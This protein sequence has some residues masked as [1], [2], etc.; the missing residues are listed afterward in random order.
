MRLDLRL[1]S[2][3]ATTITVGHD[4]VDCDGFR[5]RPVVKNGV[6]QEG[7]WA[8][9]WDG[10]RTEHKFAAGHPPYIVEAFTVSDRGVYWPRLLGVHQDLH[11]WGEPQRTQGIEIAVSL[12]AKVS[13]STLRWDYAQPTKFIFNWAPVDGFVDQLLER[14]IEPLLYPTAF[15]SW[16]PG[17][18]GESVL[19]ASAADWNATS[20]AYVA[21]CAAAADRYRGRVRHWEIWNEPN[22]RWFWSYGSNDAPARVVAR[23]RYCGMYLAARAAILT[24]APD[25]RVA[26]GGLTGLGASGDPPGSGNQWLTDLIAMPQI[27]PDNLSHLAIHPYVSN[28]QGPDDE[29]PWQ[30]HFSDIALIRGT[31]DAHGYQDTELWATEFGWKSTAPL[32]ETIQAQYVARALERLRDDFPYVTLATYFLDADQQT[33]KHGLYRDDRVTEKPA[34]AQFRAA[35]AKG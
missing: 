17:F 16:V 3:T 13:R 14:G 7:K 12:G 5:L 23:E 27:T 28:D 4:P 2:E 21:F 29:T 35:E 30:Q 24:E 32:N 20:A 1:I 19:P 15:P 6:V 22:E 11:Y 8:H 33:Y 26:L 9:T 31:L 25:A 34:A 10:T 18:A